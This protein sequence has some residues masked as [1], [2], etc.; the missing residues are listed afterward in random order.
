MNLFFAPTLIAI[1]SLKQPNSACL[2]ARQNRHYEGERPMPHN[3]VRTWMTPA[4]ITIGP[5]ETVTTAYEK[6][7]VH[8]I[9]RLPVMDRERL[10]GVITINDVRSVALMGLETMMQNPGP[11]AGKKVADVMSSPPITITQEE[12]LGEAARLMMKHKIS[13][14]PVVEEDALIGVISEADIFRL[15][16]AESWCPKTMTGPGPE[17]DEIVGLANGKT[18]H[19]RPIRPDDAARLQASLVKMSP[20]TIYDRFMGYKK[21]LPDQEARYLAS[22][23]Y[24]RHMALVATIEENIVGVARYHKLDGESDSAEFAIVIS[25]SYQHQGLGTQLM[26]RL[27]EYAQAHGI[28][29]FIGFAHEGNVRLLRFVQRSGL[30]IE[31]KFRNGIWEVRLNLKGAPFSEANI[32]ILRTAV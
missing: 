16:I 23:D 12:S 14:L 8:H 30:P 21:A 24:D 27:M 28:C 20:E 10:L 11:I 4:P 2:N 13:G 25:D 15:V 3:P 9:R 1:A 17:G 19:I 26:K 5:E 29:N 18:I 32:D 6:M 22:L 31:R 7:K